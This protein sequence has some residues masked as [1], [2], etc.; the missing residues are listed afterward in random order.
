MSKDLTIKRYNCYE[1]MR[2]I[3]IEQI[4]EFR[5]KLINQENEKKNDKEKKKRKSIVIERAENLADKQVNIIKEKNKKEL[6]DIVNNELNKDLLTD[7]ME[8]EHK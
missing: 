3:K 8:R 6:A 4:I 1:E 2:N 7:Q 5:D